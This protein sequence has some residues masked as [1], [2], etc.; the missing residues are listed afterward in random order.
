[1]TCD[2]IAW[3]SRP[4]KTRSKSEPGSG[5]SFGCPSSLRGGR[6]HSVHVKTSRANPADGTF[7][8]AEPPGGFCTSSRVNISQT[9]PAPLYACYSLLSGTYQKAKGPSYA[10]GQ[11]R[12]RPPSLTPR[13]L[14]RELPGAWLPSPG[15]HV[16]AKHE[17][18]RVRMATD[19]LAPLFRNRSPDLMTLECSHAHTTGQAVFQK[20]SS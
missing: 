14:A 4:G 20:C 11:E 19:L 12:Q 2:T 8:L 15:L 9:P 7:S 13:V 3:F 6:R 5:M 10:T 1:M 18:H 17:F 16:F